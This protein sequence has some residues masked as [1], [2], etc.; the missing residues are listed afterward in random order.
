M[1]STPTGYLMSNV[2]P[3]KHNTRN[4]IWTEQDILYIF[5]IV[6]VCGGGGGVFCV[7]WGGV[8]DNN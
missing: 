8:R 1:K 3:G 6:V 4:I 2:Q 7:C 5:R